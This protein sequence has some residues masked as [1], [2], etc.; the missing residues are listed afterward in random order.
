MLGASETNRK[1]AIDATSMTTVAAT[2]MVNRTLIPDTS[3]GG[4]DSKPITVS[5]SSRS[6]ERTGPTFTSGDRTVDR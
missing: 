3:G 1:N 4:S 6:L 2:A 5:E